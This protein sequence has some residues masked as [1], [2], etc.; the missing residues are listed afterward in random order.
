MHFYNLPFASDTL[1]KGEQQDTFFS[2]IISYLEDNHLPNDIK[3]QQSIICEAENHLLFNTL[4]FHFTVKSSKTVEHKLALCI[5]LKLSDSIFQL[6]HSGLMTSHQGLTRTYYKIRQDFFIRN[7]Y[8]YLYL[9][10]MSCRICSARRDIPFN[11]KQ[12]SWSSKVIHDFNIMEQ[13]SMD[14]KVMPTS[15]HGYNYLFVM[16]CNYSHFVIRYTLKSRKA[17]E[18]TESI[19]QKLICAHGTN[20]KEIYCD[21]DTAFKNN[22]VS[23]LFNSLGIQVKFCG[24]PSHQSNPAECAIQ[25][26]QNILIYYIAKYGNLWCVMSNMATFRQII[27]RIGHLQKLSS[28]EIVYRCKLPAISDLQLEGDDLTRPPF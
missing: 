12:R 27:F 25:S 11:Q 2:S 13:I 4:L 5:P 16:C 3:H 7:L 22:I 17:S 6:Y 20:I 28:H 9:Y 8:K 1:R 24:V 14:L 19:F 26:I 21:H 18:V 23:T 10:I 15:F